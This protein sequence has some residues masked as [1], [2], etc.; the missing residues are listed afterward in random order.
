M[1]VVVIA[2]RLS[3]IQNADRIVVFDKGNVAE[4]GTHQELIDHDG[5]YAKLVKKQQDAEKL[6]EAEEQEEQMKKFDH[7]NT[8]EEEEEKSKI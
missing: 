3:T 4:E 8:K 1:T 7:G 6:E 5:I 2:H